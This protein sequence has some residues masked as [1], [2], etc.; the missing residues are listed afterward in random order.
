[1]ARRAPLAIFVFSVAAVG[2]A[3]L[4]QYWGGLVPC[5]LC[6]FERWPYYA[7]IALT[8]LAAIVGRR[9]A[10]GGALALAGLIFAAGAC[11]AFY[12][13]GV[14]QH[15]F[16]GP[17]ACTGPTL[18]AN[19][20]EALRRQLLATP[21]VRCDAVQWSLGGVSLAGWN[22]LASLVLAMLCWRLMARL[23]QT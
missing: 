22:L 10:S 8:A 15:W 14:E 1:M 20:V 21:T 3:L 11:L 23:R 5:E 12:H 7:V 9:G 18:N 2:A 19:S 4:S 17:T 16:A 6:V 13:V